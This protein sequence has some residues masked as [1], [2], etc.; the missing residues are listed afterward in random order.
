MYLKDL[1][2]AAHIRP[3]HHDLPVEAAGAQNRRVE[4]IHTVCGRHHDDALVD[5]ETIHLHQK[6]VQSLL[7]LVVAAAHA[8]AAPSRHRVDLVDKYDTGVV[9][10]R[11]REQIA[12]T[13]GAH[14]HEHF[15]KIRTGNA[16]KGHAGLSCHCL[17]KQRLSR[18]R[19]ALQK[20]ALGDPGA[21]L[22]IFL[23][24]L[25]KVHDFF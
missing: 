1:L 17:R 15:H 9:P 11:V 12:H 2:P 10:L 24:Q 21:Y 4:D 14:A 25:Q 22:D 18:S 3:A 8:S 13:G 5:A 23:G 6:L 7:P 19:R 16:E 20:H